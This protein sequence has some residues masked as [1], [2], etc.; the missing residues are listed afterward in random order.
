MDPSK[1][2][3][4]NFN[5]NK[6]Q[7]IR[8][9][10]G[11]VVFSALGTQMA[12]CMPTTAFP[13]QAVEAWS[14]ADAQTDPRRRAVAY[15]IT[16]PNPHNRQPWMVDLR[17]TNAITLYHDVTRMLPETDPFGRQILIGHGCFIEILC[18][19][20]AQQ[21]LAADVTLWPQGQYPAQIKDWD[22]RPI[23]HIA[24][25][26]GAQPDSLFAHILK[27]HT[28]KTIFDTTRP[29]ADSLL[30]SLLKTTASSGNAGISAGGI[31][32]GGTLAADK[33]S[34]L[35]GLCMQAAVVELSTERTMMESMRLMRVGPGEILQHRDGISLNKPIIR[36][37]EA[38]G[39]FDRSKA[40]APGSAA[41]K[42]SIDLYADYT[43]TAMG[44]VW[45][46]AGN[47]R[48]AQIQAGRQ[49]VRLQL[50]ATAQGLGLHPMSQSLQEFPEMRKHYEAVH[51]LCLGKAAPAGP[52]DTT[53]HMLCRIGYTAE[54]TPPSPRRALAQ[55]F[56][57]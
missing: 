35:R 51:Q 10:G 7:F 19:A 18:L 15:A 27:R 41:F 55:F 42:G 5:M 24:L 44:F 4:A 20:L 26:T 12:G 11:G 25:K 13:A 2:F 53:L 33:V 6:R 21:G 29:V 16:A 23:A 31:T 22:R 37:L 43:K 50:A 49:Y 56:V 40:P 36:A 1:N 8:L 54:P 52:Q 9:M 32:I 30:Q 14:S 28:P 57:V 39:Q 3:G 34:A 17:E 48:D 47:Q 46:A 45:V 38:V